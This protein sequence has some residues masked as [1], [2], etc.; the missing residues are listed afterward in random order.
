MADEIARLS[1]RVVYENRWLRVREDAVRYPDGAESVYGVVEKT[2]FVVVV[3]V[4][5]DGSVHLVEQYRYPVGARS[6]EFPQGTSAGAADPEAAARAE[7]REETGLVAGRLV[8]AGRLYQASA[9]STQTYDVYLAEDLSP[10]EAALEPE[11]QGLVAR[12]MTLSAFLDL[13]RDGTVKDAA[14]VA[15][16]SLLHLKGLIRL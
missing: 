10:G 16:L 1:T 13:V 12:R 7:L 11:E 15:A 14:T 4:E 8:H 6:L 9:Y 5:P 3:P 2:D